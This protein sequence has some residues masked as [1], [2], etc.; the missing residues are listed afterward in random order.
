VEAHAIDRQRLWYWSTP[1]ILSGLA[2]IM[3]IRNIGRHVVPLFFENNKRPK[4]CGTGFLLGSGKDTY[5]ISA[6]HVLS[7]LK[8]GLRIGFFD[9]SSLREIQGVVAFGEVP[10][11]DIDI[12]AVRLDR[13]CSGNTQPVDAGLLSPEDL[14]RLGHVYLLSGYPTSR[15]GYHAVRHRVETQIALLRSPIASDEQ[16]ALLG[17]NPALQIILPLD[18]GRTSIKGKPR[19]FPHPNGMSGSPVWRIT[20]GLE[21]SV[22]GLAGV[23]IEYHE[24]RRLLVATDIAFVLSMLDLPEFK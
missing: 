20:P 14:P 23:F 9:G 6:G 2:L 17:R 22:I 12:G 3:D 19:H 1:A 18:R 24:K 8:Q 16:Y 7:P 15:S 21:P 4:S 5:L 11:S 10:G 13:G